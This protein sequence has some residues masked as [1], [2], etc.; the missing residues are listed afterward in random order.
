MEQRTDEWL[1][2]RSGKLTGSRFGALMARTQSGPSAQRKNL[3]SQLAV[4]RLIGTCVETYQ[5]S[6]MQRGNELE[7]EARFAY[8]MVT[9]RT[10]FEI[11]WVAHM[12]HEFV[13]M[14]PDG[15]IDDKGLLEI[16]C[17]S[18]Y[19]KHMQALLSGAHAGEYRW[20][21]QGQL[22]VTGRSWCDAVSYDPRYPERLQLAITRVERNES[23]IAEL[24]T[25]CIA[26]DREIN[27]LVQQMNEL[28][29][30]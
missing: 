16:K 9:G 19:D 18:A 26:A 20:Q 30:I 24:E 28:E 12:T 17:P 5:N 14:S 2:A 6:A 21:I 1:A 10:V 29:A 7:P 13:G 15:L 22:W 8:E 27:E 4:E 23:A 25:E 11:A 3:I